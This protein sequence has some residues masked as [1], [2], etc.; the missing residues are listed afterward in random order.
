MNKPD[1]QDLYRLL[2]TLYFQA[3]D[4]VTEQVPDEDLLHELLE[5][6]NERQPDMSVDQYL[7]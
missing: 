4:G 3:S 5:A 7:A 1:R 6:I 2:L